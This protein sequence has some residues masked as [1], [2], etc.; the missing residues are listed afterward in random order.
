M[1]YQGKL[2]NGRKDISSCFPEIQSICF[3]SAKGKELR[4]KFGSYRN[5]VEAFAVLNIAKLLLE[6]IDKAMLDGITIGVILLC[7]TVY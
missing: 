3:V 5:Y 4:S 1:F 7:D 2:F 6:K